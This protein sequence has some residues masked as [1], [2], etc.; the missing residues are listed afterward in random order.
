VAPK[1]RPRPTQR[2]PRA[3]PAVPSS[4]CFSNSSLLTQSRAARTRT[5]WG[6]PTVGRSSPVWWWSSPITSGGDGAAI[7]FG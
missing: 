5:D 3:Y 6:F 1:Y 2:L 7:A 4:G